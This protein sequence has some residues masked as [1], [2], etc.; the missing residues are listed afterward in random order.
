MLEVGTGITMIDIGTLI[1]A[2][3]FSYLLYR[4]YKGYY[5]GAEDDE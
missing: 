2:V 1:I 3:V 5:D 4:L